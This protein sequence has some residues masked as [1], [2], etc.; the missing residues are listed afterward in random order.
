M[1]WTM[2]AAVL[3]FALPAIAA[4]PEDEAFIALDR[5]GDGYLSM[6]ETIRSASGVQIFRN[7]DADG[8]GRLNRQ[9]F[10]GSPLDRPAIAAA[11]A[12]VDGAIN[13]RIE[14]LLAREPGLQSVAAA[15]ENRQVFLSG[16]VET[17][18]QRDQAMR[19]ALSVRGVRNVVPAV[20]VRQR[21]D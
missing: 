20:A 6:R 21:H 3:A 4:A 15:T 12:G 7:A 14:E 9:E 11:A 1:K 19:V 17:P 10:L 13:Q 5:N 16:E 18:A 8:D 2:V